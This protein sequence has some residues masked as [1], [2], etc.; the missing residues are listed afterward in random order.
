[1]KWLKYTSIALS[2]CSFFLFD[3][4]VRATPDTVANLVFWLDADD[5]DGAG[6]GPVGDPLGGTDVMTWVD[7]SPGNRDA[8]QTD[9]GRQPTV[10]NNVINGLSALR[11]AGTDRMTMANVP[12]RTIFAVVFVDGA[13]A[14]L[15]GLIGA[16]CCDDGV[17]RDGDN[18]WQ[19]PGNGD[20]FSNPAGSYFRI[21]GADN[22]A[23]PEGSF[24]ILET[25]R[26][27]AVQNHDGLGGYFNNRDLD[28]DIAEIIVYDRAL[29]DAERN[30]VGFY[31]EAKYNIPTT[32]LDPDQPFIEPLNV[33]RFNM[34][35]NVTT[36]SVDVVANVTQI[37][38]STSTAFMVFG[39][40]DEGTDPAAW[41][42][43]S[44]NF[45]SLVVGT[46]TNSLS[47]LQ[48][49]SLYYF[50]Y[51][52][53]NSS[54]TNFMPALGTFVTPAAFQQAP[55]ITTGIT[56]WLD[57]G[58]LTQANGSAV[59]FWPDLSANNN[60]A[61]QGETGQQPTLNDN[62][63]NGLPAVRFD[64]AAGGDIMGI[65]DFSALLTNSGVTLFIV[66]DIL[67]SHNYNLFSTGNNDPR[68]RENQFTRMGTFRNTRVDVANNTM[69]VTGA[70]IFEI[71]SSLSNWAFF[72][73]GASEA[74][75]A[76][77]YNIHTGIEN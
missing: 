58:S 46:F 74:T 42:G 7:K 69:P 37:G 71:E 57:A 62:A 64:T 39:L 9:A 68:W 20:T 60:A 28:G 54:G 56:V 8:T 33:N 38:T 2:C 55:C 48:P 52:V 34:A 16:T 30:I 4:T 50:R 72:L 22:N 73:D 63:I 43:S 67:S 53:T 25:F 13:A 19:H 65:S 24:H 45:N 49:N 36:G 75:A 18:A 77:Q 44:T 6:D 47:G 12:S 26:G 15:D 70:H 21:N 59:D 61:I 76:P 35:D 11:F 23:A 10:V 31:L 5:I 27:N 3:S 29:T 1:M 41:T 51:Y 40:T 17:R 32:Y 14:N 66:A